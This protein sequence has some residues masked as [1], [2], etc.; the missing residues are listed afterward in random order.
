MYRDYNYCTNSWLMMALFF[1]SIDD[2]EQANLKL[3]CDEIFGVR[4]F[5]ANIT[6]QKKYGPANDAKYFSQTHEFVIVYSKQ[7]ELFTHNLVPRDDKQ[8]KAFRNPDND[9]RGLWRASDFLQGLIL[10]VGIILLK[11]QMVKNIVRL[12]VGLGFLIKKDFLNYLKTKES[13]WG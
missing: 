5:I 1:I 8:L 11:V 10:K 2:N 13:L 9:K 7:K 12:Q 6:W 3:M 4:N